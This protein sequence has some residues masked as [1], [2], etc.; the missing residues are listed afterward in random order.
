MACRKDLSYGA[1][2]VC[3]PVR[4]SGLC[5]PLLLGNQHTERLHNLVHE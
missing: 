3:E 5:V 4:N 1:A 2:I